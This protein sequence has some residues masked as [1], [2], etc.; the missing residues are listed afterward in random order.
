M[1]LSVVEVLGKLGKFPYW[2]LSDGGKVNPDVVNYLA[3]QF[4][5]EPLNKKIQQVS[6]L[7]ALKGKD[8]PV[9]RL[10]NDKLKQAIIEY[11]TEHGMSADDTLSKKFYIS[12]LN[13]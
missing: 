5:R 1:E 11:K 13:P 8:V 10:M 3:H 2:L 6:Y 7:L 4:L 12:L 9:T